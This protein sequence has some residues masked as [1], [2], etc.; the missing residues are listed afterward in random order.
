[1]RVTFFS[2]LTIGY[3]T[4]FVIMG[5]VSSYSLVKLDE[6]RNGTAQII[7]V[8]QRILD[9]RKKLADSVLSQMGYQK[10][11]LITRDETFREQFVSAED[12]FNTYLTEALRIADTPAKKDSLNRLQAAY[13]QYRALLQAD[14]DSVK[15]NRSNAE[16]RHRQEK[17][18]LIERILEEL[19]AAGGVLVS[20]HLCADA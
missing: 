13:G 10:K 8:D 20:G 14:M 7:N 15:S 5:V 3:L 1:M 11:Y 17:E 19:K 2:R 16:M 9:L 18:M 6:L 4:I 12:D